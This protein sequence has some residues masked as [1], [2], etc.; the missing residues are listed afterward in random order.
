MATF[1]KSIG[2]LILQLLF[3]AIVGILIVGTLNSAFDLNLSLRVGPPGSS[4]FAVPQNF[5]D[6]IMTEAIL[7][8]CFGL[9][10]ILYKSEQIWEKTKKN[11]LPTIGILITVAVA[12]IISIIQ[13]KPATDYNDLLRA[14]TNN[15]PILAEKIIHKIPVQPEKSAELFLVAMY[16]DPKLIQILVQ[17][18]YDIN[19]TGPDGKNI[20]MLAKENDNAELIEWLTKNGAR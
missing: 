16:Q 11:P 6:L 14:V 5:T 4:F 10:F 15:D 18:G 1:L 3:V 12:V 17:A 13:F 9:V 7:L 20:L 19:A 8:V 2:G